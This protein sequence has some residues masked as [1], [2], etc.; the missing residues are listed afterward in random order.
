MRLC[1]V[2]DIHIRPSPEECFSARLAASPDVTRFALNELCGRPDLAGEELHRHLFDH[3]GMGDAVSALMQA[4]D[5]DF[6]G[7]GYSAGGTAI[8]RAAAEGLPFTAIFCV[9]STRLREEKPIAT[10]NHVFFGME[11]KNKPSPKWLSTIPSR[12]TVFQGVGHTYY[13][14][15]ESDA[16]RKTCAQ[17]VRDIKAWQL[18]TP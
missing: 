13:L 1:I 17:I 4:L 9:S 2:T 5:G 16:G 10:P 3:G 14:Q 7:L 6:F 11:D 8:W 15:P 18:F 12:V